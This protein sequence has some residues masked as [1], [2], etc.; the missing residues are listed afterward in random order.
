MKVNLNA[1]IP[2]MGALA[3]D[4]YPAGRDAYP[5]AWA[6]PA[7]SCYAAC[8]GLA[9]CLKISFSRSSRPVSDGPGRPQPGPIAPRPAPAARADGPGHRGKPPGGHRVR[10]GPQAGRAGG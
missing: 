10:G 8:V 7:V 5:V 6:T 1:Y 9:S 3:L 4:S 2:D